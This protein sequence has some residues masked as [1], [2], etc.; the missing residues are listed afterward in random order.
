M[1]EVPPLN[2]FV[3]EFMI[4]YV[5][6]NAG[7]LTFTVIMLIN[8]LLEFAYYLRLIKIIVWSTPSE[9]L[10]KIR[11]APVLMLIPTTL[12]ALSCIII[13]LYPAPFIEMASKAAQAVI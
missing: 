13:G 3:I 8:I 6:V 2:G 10:K 4:V 1:R 12:M 5:G 9:N 11:K 7:M